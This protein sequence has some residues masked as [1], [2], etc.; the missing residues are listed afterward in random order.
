MRNYKNK[1]GGILY[2]CTSGSRLQLL[3]GKIYIYNVGDIDWLDVHLEVYKTL[4][5]I[6]W[7]NMT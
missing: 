5:N 2:N 3:Q 7:N 4:K 6:K 1:N